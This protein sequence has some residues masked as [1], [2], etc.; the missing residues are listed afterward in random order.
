MRHL[1]SWRFIFRAFS[2]LSWTISVIR[3]YHQP[4]LVSLIAFIV[5]TV[6]FI[7]SFF[8]SDKSIFE[9]SEEQK[10][11]R[12]RRNRM[13]MLKKVKKIWVEGVLKKSLHNAV[14][15]ELGLEERKDAVD[16]PDRPWGM[17]LQTGGQPNRVLP[18][19]T[20][21]ADVFDDVGQVLLILGEPGSGKTTMLLE[22][23]RETISR[24]EKDPV[25]PIPVVFNLSS[26][27]EPAQSLAGWLVD[28]L[29]SKYYIPE[30][31]AKAWVESYQLLLLLD[32]LDEVAA[33]RRDACVKAI[34]EFRMEHLVP[35]V[36]CSRK[37]EY[38]ALTTLLKVDSAVC[39]QPLTEK[40]VSDYLD[41]FGEE[42]TAVRKML[43]DD[44]PL[45]ELS[46]SPLMLN[47]MTL[48]YKGASVED[49]Q[50]LDIIEGRRKHL[51]NKYIDGMFNRL[52]RTRSEVYPRDKTIKWLS[53]LA[54]NMSR[55]AQSVFLIEKMQPAWLQTQFQQRQYTT[56]T[57]LIPWLILG[58]SYGMISG[59]ILGPIINKIGVLDFGPI[60]V[61]I[62]VLVAA[63]IGGGIGRLILGPFPGF[64]LLS[65]LRQISEPQKTRKIVKSPKW[66]WRNLFRSI[67]ETKERIETV[68]TMKWSWKKAKKLLILGL[69]IGPLAGLLGGPAFGLILW[70]IFRPFFEWKELAI[71]GS[72]LCMVLGP[73]CSTIILLIGGTMLVGLSY[74]EVEERTV[75][76]QG[77]Q[78]SIK[79]AI[80]VFSITII[81]SALLAGLGVVVLVVS[82]EPN[83]GLNDVTL[84]YAVYFVLSLVFLLGFSLALEY[85][86]LSAIQHYVLRFILYRNAYIPWNMVKFLDYAAEQIFL[87][88]VGS[89]YKFIHRLIQEHFA[90][91]RYSSGT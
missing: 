64:Y 9:I 77:I 53:W 1:L 52:A 34:N 56:N 30:K 8:A 14:L 18:P 91:L 6:S 66:S 11:A 67:D 51:F 25:Q 22:L 57:E 40:Q 55:E 76:N 82:L 71:N 23:A 17:I 21:I 61:L 3:F 65:F 59:L 27:I 2:V 26:W 70:L 37:A 20:R 33:Q 12:D 75:P 74:G 72:I 32:G 87:Q 7:G 54:E 80:I 36:I 15:I 84:K 13:A 46:R 62:I 5:G 73:V 28:E 79:N 45:R 90:S 48:A 50:H 49:L 39:I 81:A 78:Q 24:A 41:N 47:I 83:V 85:G 89:G 10:L 58:V 60:G 19:G 38:K 35:I 4:D 42:L 69:I 86:G 44:E 88:K 63:L 31:I 43:Q 29:M 16:T 68:E